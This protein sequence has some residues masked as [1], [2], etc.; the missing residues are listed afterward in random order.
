[1]VL[2]KGYLVNQ[3]NPTINAPGLPSVAVAAGAGVDPGV[4]VALDATR[5]ELAV[6][7]LVG[8]RPRNVLE[9]IYL[10]LGAKHRPRSGR[11]VIG[12]FYNDDIYIYTVPLTLCML[13]LLYI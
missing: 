1:M 2:P 5:C 6:V 13:W 3:R 11:L 9:E 12:E 10:C 4:A 7:G 8:H